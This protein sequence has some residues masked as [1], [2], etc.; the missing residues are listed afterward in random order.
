VVYVYGSFVSCAWDRECRLTIVEGPDR[1][2]SY[3]SRYGGRGQKR[4]R[5]KATGQRQSRPTRPLGGPS[6]A[7]IA[8]IFHV[9]ARLHSACLGIQ[10]VALERTS[11]RRQ[12]HLRCERHPIEGLTI[13]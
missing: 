10:P 13:V 5:H 11:W 12:S 9:D 8:S 1:K 4:L 6:M 3:R 7:S 2:L